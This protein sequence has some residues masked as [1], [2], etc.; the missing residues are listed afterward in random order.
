MDDGDPVLI[1]G[2]DAQEFTYKGLELVLGHRVLLLFVLVLMAIEVRVELLGDDS[3][4]RGL[5]LYIG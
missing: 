3:T 5:I 1:L 2:A 4:V